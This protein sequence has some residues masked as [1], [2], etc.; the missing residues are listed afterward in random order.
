[1]TKS[2]KRFVGSETWWMIWQNDIELAAPDVQ[3][4]S[5]ARG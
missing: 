3:D 4:A 1:M 5:S 2:E